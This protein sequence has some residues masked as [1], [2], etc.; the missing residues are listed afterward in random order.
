MGKARGLF[1]MLFGCAFYFQLNR[2]SNKGKPI[3]GKFMQRMGLLFAFGCLHASLLW[4]GDILMAYAICGLA[5]LS[6]RNFTNQQLFW[7]AA[8][9]I[10]LVPLLGG[11]VRMFFPFV[12][13]G[14]ETWHAM[15]RLLATNSYA[16]V[17][18]AN[19]MRFRLVT[20]QPYYATDYLLP[21]LG[22]FMIGYWTMQFGL[23]EKMRRGKRFINRTML[24]AFLI[25]L[26]L[27]W[28]SNWPYNPLK[29]LAI[30][31][32]DNALLYVYIAL[33][34]KA[35]NANLFSKVFS[36][37]A[38]TGQ[39][40]LTHYIMQS[41]IALYLFDGVGLGL[42]GHLGPIFFVP[43]AL[44]I[45]LSQMVFTIIW[46]KVFQMGPLEFIWRSA[47][48]GKWQPMLRKPQGTTINA[49]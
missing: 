17:L 29:G 9:L 34:I 7:G 18:E 25:F 42:T 6:M 12:A 22:Y 4:S 39:M 45:F 19:W 48:A 21:V 11:T 3:V 43:L 1:A 8:G 35:F 20:F 38:S 2:S 15:G 24:A 27:A 46:L 36:A 49:K 26:S 13:D 30:G 41:L 40:T 28:V 23:F 31:I 47:L 5:L 16:N 10:I 44:L 32:R 14:N 33:V 37:L